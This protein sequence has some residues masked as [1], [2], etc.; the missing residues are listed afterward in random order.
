MAEDFEAAVEDGLRLSKRI[1]FGKDRAVAPPKPHTAME[2]AAGCSYLPNSPMLYAVITDPAIVDNPDMPS[3]Q[4]HVHGRCDPPAL[5]PLQMNGV[6]LEVDC[7]LDTAFVTVSGTWRVHCVMGSRSCDCRFALPMGEQGSIL[8]VEVEVP[9]KSYRTEFISM[10]NEKGTHN[11]V[12]AEGG[13]FLKAHIFT[14]T[15]PQVD[16]GTNISVKVKWSQKLSYHDGQFT[17]RIPFSFPEYVTP[18]AKKISKREK[19]ELNVNAGPET[20]VLCKTTSHPLKERHRQVGKLGFHYDSEVI[21]WSNSDFMF[22]YTVS[23]S[24]T[25]GAVLLNPPLLGDVDRRDMFYCYL[26]P[27]KQ[28]SGKVFRKEVIFVV[29]I[30]GSM[31]GQPLEDTKRALFAAL[32]KLNPK[33]LFNVIA[34]NGETCMFSSILEP[35]TAKNV[36]SVIPWVNSN[37]VANGG[38]N[39]L[40]PL[41]QAI[42]ML[43][44]NSDSIPIIFLITDGAVEDE[45][46]IC[47][48]MRNQLRNYKNM[49]PRI[50]TLGIGK[51]CN[52]YF[53]R[54]LAS[55]SRGLHDA[56]SDV[57]SIVARLEVLFARASSIF[58]ADIAL[59]NL[60]ELDDLEVFPTQIP[61]LSSESPLIVS[62]RYRGTFPEKLK[63]N[64]RLADRS[65]FTLDLKVEEAKEIPIGKME[66]KHQIELL[67]AQAWYSENQELEKK[68]AKMSVQ[69]SIISEY[70]NMVLLAT[71][72]GKANADSTNAK[73]AS[74][75][76]D[77]QKKEEPKPEVIS[78]AHNLGLGFGNLNATAENIPSGYGDPEPPDAGE[79]F[80]KAGCSCC[81]RCWRHCCCMCCIQACSRMND[82]CAIAF[83]QLFGA[84]ACLGCYSCCGD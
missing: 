19:I 10:E 52:H 35:A 36:E 7:H 32:S 24:Q 48:T 80:L 56:A 54:M 1:Y 4:P 84:L 28:Q 75:K 38:T 50:Y 44:D 9:R 6:S 31:R 18:A 29:D 58:L 16:G 61:D 8:G 51:F 53:L 27:G 64:G 62:G 67:T 21:S 3:Y 30:S 46:N 22:T 14:F 71:Q 39:I 45:R 11:V 66:A 34:F 42:N 63:V 68:I 60:D 47:D 79:V 59:Q 72:R 65:S 15:V 49:C 55:T 25:F 33:D 74:R 77:L 20:E 5:I 83:T 73:K 13:G 41:N 81:G 26:F 57:E 78:T 82:Q 37:F 70:T 2:R 76:V 69:N 17:L 43:S 12:K 40:L 23:S